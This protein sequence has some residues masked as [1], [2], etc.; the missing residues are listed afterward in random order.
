MPVF[1]GEKYLEAALNSILAQTYSDFELIISDNASTDRT[2]EICQVYVEK[3]QRIYYHRNPINLGAAPNYNLAF[4]LSS[5]EY[6]KWA[7]YDDI[8]AP[9]F[10][11][12]CVD[13]LDRNPDIVLCCPLSRV[14]DENGKI[15][16]DYVYK[17][18]AASPE[19]HIRFK[20]FALNPDKCYQVS[21][22]IRA[23]IISK[24]ALH[25]S[26]PSSDLVFLAELALYG[27]FYE[28]PE[29]LFSPRNH[30]DQSTKGDLSIERN[31]V[32]FFDTSNEGRITLP[33]WLLLMGFLKAIKNGPINGYE[34]FFCNLQMMRWFFKP[35]HFRALAK[36][37]LLAGQKYVAGILSKPRE[38]THTLNKL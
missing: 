6:F 33:K 7:D 15:L 12:K 31:R 32:V 29:Y 8:I 20:E 21:G 17:V 36:D 28:L 26:Y 34:K 13:V 22:L 1:N 2:A 23:N 37:L 10:L 18:K 38:K 35:D 3:D 19:P 4:E 25:G 11:M 16:G 9:D 5:S 27:R 24:T 30:P 14:I